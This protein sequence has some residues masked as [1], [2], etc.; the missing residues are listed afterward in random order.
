MSTLLELTQG[1][2]S[3]SDF[4]GL[5]E[6]MDL[7]ASRLGKAVSERSKAISKIMQTIDTI[8]VDYDTTN[9]DILGEAYIELIS[10]FASTAD[11]KAG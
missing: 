9:A 11:K 2:D 1:Q 7:K 10:K 5:F 4:I 3:E 6:N 8:E